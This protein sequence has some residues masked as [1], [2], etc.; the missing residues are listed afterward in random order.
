MAC[1]LGLLHPCVLYLSPMFIKSL[2]SNLGCCG[3]EVLLCSGCEA[4]LEYKSTLKTAIINE[5]FSKPW[6]KLCWKALFI[7]VSSPDRT[8]LNSQYIRPPPPPRFQIHIYPSNLCRSVWLMDSVFI[9][10]F[11]GDFPTKYWQLE[12]SYCVW[13]CLL[14]IFTCKLC[15]NSWVSIRY[16]SLSLLQH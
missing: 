15:C 4:L 3:N 2:P 9:C 7:L 13:W 1:E 8:Q 12:R 6:R 10:V 14:W 16:T 11:L 5:G